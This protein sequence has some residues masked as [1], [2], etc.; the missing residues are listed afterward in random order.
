LSVVT[1][2]PAR[3]DAHFHLE[4][5]AASL[6]QDQSG[7]PQ[8]A[9]PCGQDATATETG[10]ITPYQAG[11][12]VTITLNE[13]IFHPGHYRVAIAP[14]DPSE[15]PDEPPVTPGSTECG[16]T[17]IMDPPVFPVLADGVLLHD[18]PFGGPQTIEVTLPDDLECEHCTLQILEFMSNHAAS[19]FYH[20]C[21]TI[22]VQA[23]PVMTTSATSSSAASTGPGG[24]GSGGVGGAGPGAT[25]T[26]PGMPASGE[27]TESDDG[28]ACSAVG[29]T[30]GEP[31]LVGLGAVGLLAMA[32]RRRRR[33]TQ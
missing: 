3:S 13:T 5:P 22:A 21:A 7:N 23:E 18:A 4:T 28:C 24:G 17:T 8:K 25:T 32:L 10:I 12:T 26:G 29:T 31:G 20:H 15:L 27:P 1:L 2:A 16:S 14:N 9:P 33:R 6:D 11:T 30:R 19:C